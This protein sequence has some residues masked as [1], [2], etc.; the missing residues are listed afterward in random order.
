MLYEVITG[1]IKQ[2]KE[3]AIEH[4]LKVAAEKAKMIRRIDKFD[5]E[6]ISV[7]KIYAYERY[8][9]DG[10]VSI[11]KHSILSLKDELFKELE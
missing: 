1:L 3:E 6:L 5:D 4:T 10:D 7:H 2:A 11:D 8:Y 9:E